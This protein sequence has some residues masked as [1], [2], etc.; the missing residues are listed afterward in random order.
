[1]SAFLRR[2]LFLAGRSAKFRTNA[3]SIPGVRKQLFRHSMDNYGAPQVYNPPHSMEKYKEDAE[4]QAKCSLI[5]EALRVHG[6]CRFQVSGSSMLPTL[7]PGDLVRIERK[8]MTQ[9]ALGDIILHEL[10]A[11]LF[12]HRLER[13]STGRTLVHFTTRGDAMPQPDPS[14]SAGRL[15][16]VLA[17]VRR[18]DTWVSLPRRMSAGARIV[19]KLARKSP[20]FTQLLLLTNT[21]HGVDVAKL[22]QM[23]GAL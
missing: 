8:S 9:L 2:W 23:A 4:T 12:L 22:K 21:R 13:M 18:N 20:L 19:A 16:G 7:W 5:V 3:A 17:G 10:D 14:F 6:S 15:L 11:R 1:M